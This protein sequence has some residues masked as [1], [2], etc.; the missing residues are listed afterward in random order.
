MKGSTFTGTFP[1][2]YYCHI[3]V[4]GD[5]HFCPC[6]L[7]MANINECSVFP[8][9]LILRASKIRGIGLYGFFLRFH[10]YLHLM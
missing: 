7:K 2:I 4:N 10:T 8:K 6:I 9:G 5:L 3:D 1:G